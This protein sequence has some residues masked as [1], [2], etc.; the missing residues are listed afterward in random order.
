MT[1]E[2]NSMTIA[3]AIRWTNANAFVVGR[4]ETSS[5]PFHR[6]AVLHLW[7]GGEPCTLMGR[8]EST[9]PGS[10]VHPEHFGS[11]SD[12]QKLETTHVLQVP[13]TLGMESPQLVRSL[14]PGSG[15]E[16][17]AQ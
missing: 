11:G 10:F 4:S 8:D 2:M 3:P 1:P 9:S 14:R 12:H 15:H 13:E 7:I 6:L 5:Q 16:G 17:F